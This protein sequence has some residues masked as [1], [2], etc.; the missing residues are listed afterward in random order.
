MYVTIVLVV[1]CAAIVVVFS[2]EFRNMFK[3]FFSIPGFKLFIPLA[4]ASWV[5]EA[6]EGWGLWGLLWIKEGLH[7]VIHFIDELIPFEL[8][9]TFT[10]ILHLFLLASLPVWILLA[11]AK[12]KGMYEP[13]PH[14]YQI[15]AV[16]WIIGAILLT[17]HR[18]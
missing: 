3:K 11:L 7:S 14:T 5:V 12:S 16:L 4:F 17:V 1:F 9:L 6:Y 13:W 18:P 10:H 2:Q 15:G 8:S